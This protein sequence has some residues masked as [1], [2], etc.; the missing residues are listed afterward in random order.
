[1]VNIILCVQFHFA[2]IEK[3]NSCSRIHNTDLIIAQ[4]I[5]YYNAKN[6][7]KIAKLTRCKRSIKLNLF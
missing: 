4:T 5:L 3:C 7:K 2:D 1:M 6:T